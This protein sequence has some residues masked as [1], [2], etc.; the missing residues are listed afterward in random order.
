MTSAGATAARCGGVGQRSI[1]SRHDRLDAGDR[2]LLQHDLADEH[3]P[4]R[5]RPGRRHGRSRAAPAYQSTIASPAARGARRSRGRRGGHGAPVCRPPG[6]ARRPGPVRG[7]RTTVPRRAAPGGRPARRTSTGDAGSSCWSCCWPSWAAPAGWASP[8]SPTAAATD[9]AAVRQP[10]VPAACARARGALAERASR[11]RPRRRA[12]GG[13]RRTPA[14]AAPE[15]GGRRAVHRRH[16]G[17]RGAR[18]GQ[19]RR[20]QQADLRARGRQRSP[21]CPACAPWTRGCRRSSCWTPAGN[22]VWGSNDCF[23]EAG[24][25]VRTLAPG[26]VVVLPAGLGRA[27]QR[28][29]VHGRAGHPGARRLRAARP[30]RHQGVRGRRDHAG[31]S[32]GLSCSGRGSRSRRGGRGPRGCRGRG[33]R[34]RPRRRAGPRWWPPAASAGRRSGRPA[35]R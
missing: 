5:R 33:P 30:A 2:R 9:A 35:G 12:P 18:A 4:R 16:A 32:P 1:H 13:G 10:A 19:R 23:P 17:P 8:C 21:P 26:E 34:R 3:R 15:P 24:S 14:P 29:D 7:R 20:G 31:L 25:D 11:R 22:R 27:D 6:A 28:A